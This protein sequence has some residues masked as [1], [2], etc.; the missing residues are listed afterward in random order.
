MKKL[1]IVVATGSLLWSS[2][3]SGQ[4]NWVSFG[5]DPGATKFSTLAQINTVERQELE[6]RLDL[7]YGRQVG[8]LRKHAA[9]CRQRHVLQ[10]A[11]RRL[12][13]RRCDRA[14]DLEIRDDRHGAARTVPTGPATADVGPRIFSSDGRMGWRRSTRRP[15]R[16]SR[17]SAR[18]DSSPECACRRRR[19]STRTS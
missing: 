4:N 14:A 2:E 17:P 18:R 16:W 13:A 7:P 19:R 5:Q 15:A 9:R 8:L 10:R 3:L 1:L 12:C 11:E 6:A